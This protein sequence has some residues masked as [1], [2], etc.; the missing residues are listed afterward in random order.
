MDHKD[1]SYYFFILVTALLIFTMPMRWIGYPSS[2]VGWLFALVIEPAL[3]LAAWYGWVGLLKYLESNY[4]NINLVSPDKFW[5]W[6]V[7]FIIP[8]V[9]FIVLYFVA[10]RKVLGVLQKDL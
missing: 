10:Y 6:I 1:L 8:N 3:L 4:L 5:V 2:Y 7:S 9:L